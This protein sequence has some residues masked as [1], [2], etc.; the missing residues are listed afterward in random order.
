M[1]AGAAPPDFGRSRCRDWRLEWVGLTLEAER[2]ASE[3]PAPAMTRSAEELRRNLGL[4]SVDGSR[5]R[6]GALRSRL[7]EGCGRYYRHVPGA[8]YEFE[9]RDPRSTEETMAVLSGRVAEYQLDEILRTCHRDTARLDEL[10][11][12]YATALVEVR[13]LEVAADLNRSGEEARAWAQKVAAG[14]EKAEALL[15]EAEEVEGAVR[16]RCGTLGEVVLERLEEVQMAL[17]MIRTV[18]PPEDPQVR[19]ATKVAVAKEEIRTCL[20]DCQDC[21]DGLDQGQEELGSLV[22]E[23]GIRRY[24]LAD[25]SEAMDRLTAEYGDM[26]AQARTFLYLGSEGALFVAAADA[27]REEG[28]ELGWIVGGDDL[29]TVRVAQRFQRRTSRELADLVT[30][31]V[32]LENQIVDLRDRLERDLT[33]CEDARIQ[34]QRD[35]H[36]LKREEAPVLE[37]LGDDGTIHSETSQFADAA[38][39][40]RRLVHR[41]VVRATRVLDKVTPTGEVEEIPDVTAASPVGTWELVTGWGAA[42]RKA[43]AATLLPYTGAY[44]ALPDRVLH[45]DP[46]SLAAM[47][48]GEALVSGPQD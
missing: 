39:E 33:E 27:G 44:L 31:T 45:L 2:R 23:L 18:A 20:D 17:D 32:A 9:T 22:E 21:L 48:R 15:R 46:A 26:R 29:E 4:G 47:A 28:R 14:R 19:R 41:A 8:F 30:S 34:C 1:V 38:I 10:Q 6:R 42:H 43:A 7:L 13:G 40:V 36:E 5:E 12:R 11:R 37:R 3:D 35:L 24:E 16:A 25:K